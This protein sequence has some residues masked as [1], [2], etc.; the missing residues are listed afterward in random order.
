MRE[1]FPENLPTRL[2]DVIVF[3]VL[4]S[5]LSIVAIGA[6]NLLLFGLTKLNLQNE[7]TLKGLGWLGYVLVIVSFIIP[8]VS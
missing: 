5:I 8:L 4:S 1:W 2:D 7:Q 3:F 6:A